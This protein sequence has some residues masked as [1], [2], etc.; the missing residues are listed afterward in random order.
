MPRQVFDRLKNLG[1]KVAFKKKEE[2]VCPVI[3]EDKIAEY[4]EKAV[5]KLKKLSRHGY[6]RITSRG[7]SAIFAALFIAKKIN[8]KP[9]LIIPDQGGWIS[10]KRYPLILNFAVKE[11]KT[12]YGIIDLDDLKEQSKNASALIFTSFAGYFAE[13]PLKKIFK[14]CK[15]NNCLVIEDASGAVGDRK[16][17]NGKYSDIIVASFGKWSPVNSG[18]G[19]FIS[20][21]NPEHFNAAKE[22]FSMISVHPSFFKEVIPK[23]NNQRL[24]SILEKAEAIKKDLKKFQIVHPDSRGLNVVVKFD[25]QTLP[26]LLDYCQKNSL[27]YVLCP[28]Y[29]R[30]NER[31]ISIEAKRIDFLKKIC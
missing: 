31:A 9:K 24:K 4:Q 12:H 6:V 16:L 13:Q 14:I 2:A 17:C 23:L 19:G 15:A 30:L 8:P 10:F 3:G 5:K 7:N 11:V 1:L 18:Y 28:N 29:I 26:Q 25:A 22:V 20:S 27:Q 21:N